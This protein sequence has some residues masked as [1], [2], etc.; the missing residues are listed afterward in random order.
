MEPKALPSSSKGGVAV[1]RGWEVI[2]IDAQ[3][4]EVTLDDGSVI[5]YGKC[6]L[7]PG[8]YRIISFLL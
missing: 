7:A 3:K 1:A 8:Q 6:L 5:A 4:K 2:A